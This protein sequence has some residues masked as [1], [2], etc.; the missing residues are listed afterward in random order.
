VVIFSVCVLAWVE[1]VDQLPISDTSQ[2]I[3]RGKRKKY[4]RAMF[5]LCSLTMKNIQQAF[6]HRV[7]SGAAVVEKILW[8][9]FDWLQELGLSR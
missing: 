5:D 4:S 3:I 2:Y 7:Y 6:F 1:F 9:I 8:R